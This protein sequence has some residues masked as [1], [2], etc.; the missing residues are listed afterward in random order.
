MSSVLAI[1][2]Y[3]DRAAALREAAGTQAA[4]ALTLVDSLDDAVA[5]IERRVPEVILISPLMPPA[6]EAELIAR[7]RVL[8]KNLYVQTLI[9]PELKTAESKPRGLFAVK[10]PK[11]LEPD[12]D[13]FAS[14]LKTYVGAVREQR[15]ER[16]ELRY[17]GRERRT[18]ERRTEDTAPAVF[19]NGGRVQVLDRSETGVQVV[20]SSLLVPGR[21]VDVKI[22]DGRSVRQLRAAIAWGTFERLPSSR[23]L[24][25]AGLRFTDLAG[26]GPSLVLTSARPAAPPAAPP[27]ALVK[28]APDTA[29][30]RAP[31]LGRQDLPR[32]SAIRL[33]GGSEADLLN[34]SS[35]G[36]LLETSSKFAPGYSASV[37]LCGADDEMIVPARVVRSEVGTVTARG[38][39]YRAAVAFEKAIDLGDL[40]VARPEVDA[41]PKAVADWLRQLSM[42]LHRGGDPQGLGKR[43]TDGLMQ[44]LSARDVEIRREPVPPPD[45]CDSIYFTISHEEDRRA[46]LQVTFDPD[47]A[48]TALGFQILR[49]ASALAAVL[50]HCR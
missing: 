21:F 17:G 49:A 29:V 33:P 7:L 2:P 9:T 30:E 42:E 12:P 36:M 5:A 19:V 16:S 10:R 23:V 50:F 40:G 46:V 15:V 8:P 27:M 1:E 38:V 44:L 14:Q 6:E 41:T 32:L 28:R 43:M 48:P 22:D 39:R 4:E 45:G 37:R 20:C 24:C 3:P 47:Q 25:R 26:P 11:R 31:R 34:L 13:A 18:A 35:T